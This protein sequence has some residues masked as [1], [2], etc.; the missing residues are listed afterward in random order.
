MLDTQ[1]ENANALDK[2][3][4]DQLFLNARTHTAWT[5]R[6]ISED[7]LR[8]LYDLT[9][10]GPTSMNNSPAR[11]LFLTSADSKARLKPHLSVGNVDKTMAAPVTVIVAW[12]REFYERM[13]ELFP[14]SEA[15]RDIMKAGAEVN[16]FRNGTLQAAY[17]ILGARALGLDT[18]PMSGFSIEGVDREFFANDPERSNWTTNFL[19]NL[20][21]GSGENQKPRLPRLS[22]DEAAAI[23]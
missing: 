14:H 13:P 11:F 22:F 4:I 15:A 16:G 7:T 23:L 5:E 18:G 12:D 20:G 3:A 19:V 1:Y 10:M 21:Y 9:R 6:K 2:A 17:L 8:E